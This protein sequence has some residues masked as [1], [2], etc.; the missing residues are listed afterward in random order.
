MRLYLYWPVMSS[1]IKRDIVWNDGVCF[2]CKDRP[3]ATCSSHSVKMHKIVSREKQFVILGMRYSQ[4]FETKSI[5]VPRCKR[6]KS[7][8]KWFANGCIILLPLLGIS[9]ILFLNGVNFKV[10]HLKI[11]E[12]LGL[13]VAVIFWGAIVTGIVAKIVELFWKASMKEAQYYPKIREL[14]RHR[15]KMG[16]SPTYKW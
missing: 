6:C 7:F 9:V 5:N 2:F 11:T 3:A 10:W 14:R 4:S 1:K 13:G 16:S 12:I 8:H 15:W